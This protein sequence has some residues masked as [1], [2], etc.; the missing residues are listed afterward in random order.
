M[1]NLKSEKSADE[2][3]YTVWSKNFNN[4]C[5]FIGKDNCSI[6]I[7]SPLALPSKTKSKNILKIL[8]GPKFAAKNTSNEL[9]TFLKFI[10]IDI[11]DSIV[12]YTNIYIENRRQEIEYGR[13]RDCNSTSRVEIMALFGILFLIS[14]KK[15]NGSNALELW[16]SDGT[17]M[18]ILR[19]AFSSKR[20][21]FLLRSLRFDNVTTRKE[22][23]KFDKLAATRQFYSDFLDNC[24]NNYSP[25]EYV[26]IDE[27]LHPFRGRCGFIQYMPN[28]P[29][30]YGM[31]L[32]VMC[33]SQTYYTINFEIYCGTQPSGSPYLMSNKPIDIV[34]R[35]VEIIKSSNRNV[36]TDNYYSSYPLATYLREIGLTFIGTLKKK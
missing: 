6:W 15:G 26:T 20:F 29:A 24:K 31:K 25:G 28:K 3:E 4:F 16:K 30:K 12:R 11:I 23:I 13:S 2:K 21:L 19:A 34:K 32:Y 9:E 35:L 8:P 33:D 22:H 1:R 5:F 14:V 18:M 36:T 17:G 10:S 27:M 7:S